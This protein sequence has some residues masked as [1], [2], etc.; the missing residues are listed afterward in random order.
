MKEGHVFLVGAGPGDPDLITMKAYRL[1]QEAE[2]VVYDRL[3]SAAI[4]DLIPRGVTKIDVGKRP[5]HH[6][7][8]Q[9][10]I[11]QTLIRLAKSG[12]TVV[13]LK[14]GDPFLFGRGGEEALALA[15]ARIRF[16]VVPGITSAQ[17]CAARHNLPL[18][19][20]KLAQG[21]RYITG[22][23]RAD[24]NLE[25]DWVGLADPQTTLVV[26]MGLANIGRIARRLIAHGRDPETPV[27]AV[28]RATLPDERHITSTLATISTD[29]RA[30][31]LPS[32]TLIIIGDVVRLA[33][34][35]GTFEH[36][37]PQ[38]QLAALH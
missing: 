24:S 3:V 35:L 15:A 8:P 17:A 33:A 13:R 14:G 19:H 22:H 26:Y 7:V 12:R 21:I 10:E 38:E 34:S 9:D 25:F 29:V 36:V 28:S 6:P 30:V 16:E 27:L 23:C 4:L 5:H 18:T 11:N 20:R 2:I 32:P 31:A 1:L 37:M